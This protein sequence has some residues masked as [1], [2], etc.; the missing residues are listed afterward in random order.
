VAVKGHRFL[1]EAWSKL[2]RWGVQADLW[3]AGDGPLRTEL[4][5]MSASLGVRGSVRFLG[6]IP[7][8]RLLEMYEGFDIAAAVLASVDLG[9]GNREGIPV[10]LIEAMS[11]GVPVVGTLAGG[12][13]ELIQG[14]TGLL[15]RPGDSGELAAALRSLLADPA[16][17]RRLGEFGRL[18]VAR[19]FD[20]RRVAAELSQ[21]FEGAKPD[22]RPLAAGVAASLEETAW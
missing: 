16:R 19:E 8:N 11:Y 10:A 1:L 9:G 12:T 21:A 18:H 20:V 7:H 14:G 13:G 5:R 6:T 3:L 4:E 15:V 17:A 2:L 22:V